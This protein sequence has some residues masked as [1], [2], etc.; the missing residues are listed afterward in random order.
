MPTDFQVSL[1]IL[2]SGAGNSPAEV[3]VLTLNNG[4]EIVPAILMLRSLQV[5]SLR[6][7]SLNCQVLVPD[8]CPGEDRECV[9]IN[10][11]LP[12]ATLPC[13]FQ[14]QSLIPTQQTA[15][16]IE[17]E[18]YPLTPDLDPSNNLASASVHFSPVTQIP[19][20][21]NVGLLFAVLAMVIIGSF[22]LR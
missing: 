11:L 15:I 12:M 9:R 6:I 2:R 7:T 19:T 5:D 13:R 16:A 17:A 18:L 1:R 4:P 14:V 21:G 8:F 20:I 3:E 22:K 10:A